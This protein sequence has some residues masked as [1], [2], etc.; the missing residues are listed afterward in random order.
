MT[1][2]GGLFR[3]SLGK[4]G[5][6]K[7]SLSWL[8]V[9]ILF[10]SVF[11]VD[12][13]LLYPLEKQY[14]PNPR[15]NQ[16]D[17]II[18][19]SGNLDPEATEIW[20][21]VISGDAAERN[22]AF[23]ALARKHTDARLVYT[24]GSSNLIQK[25]YKAADVAERLFAEQGLDLSRITFERESRNTAEHPYNVM[26]LMQPQPDEQWVLITT[27]W[28]MPRAMGV[29]CKAGWKVTPYPVD[30]RSR[31]GSLLKAS[32]G[33]AGRLVRVN[34]AVREW[35]GLIAYKLMGRSC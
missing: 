23:I 10:V 15:L 14:I 30:F 33:G 29:F 6:A 24:G 16:V 18:A 7:Y 11:P 5:Y 20:N 9:I 27:G 28:H 12:D 21:Q 32:W 34:V 25:S 19:L 13:W 1:L 3:C 8:L 31:P 17:G 26:E 4:I 2:L 35:I 22:F